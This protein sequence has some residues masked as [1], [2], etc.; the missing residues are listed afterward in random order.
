M[1]LAPT[2]ADDLS[3]TDSRENLGLRRAAS[4]LA[5]ALELFDV[6]GDGGDRGMD[7]HDAVE[8]ADE[9]ME[10]EPC[11]GDD[12]PS[13]FVIERGVDGASWV[14]EYESE[15][16]EERGRRMLRRGDVQLLI[17]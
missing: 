12:A 5:D 2:L 9:G 11:D 15:E 6:G 14:D 10:V 13:G 4:S 7:W 16:D 1:S 17:R 8:D 3:L